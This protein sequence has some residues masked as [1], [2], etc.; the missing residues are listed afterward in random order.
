MNANLILLIIFIRR[1][2]NS[3]QWWSISEGTCCRSWF[4]ISAKLIYII[5]IIIKQLVVRIAIILIYQT[6]CI[7]LWWYT[8]LVR[9][10]W[11]FLMIINFAAINHVELRLAVVILILIHQIIILIIC[12]NA[13]T[14][15]NLEIKIMFL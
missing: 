14:M 5:I 2:S 13:F 9:N 7:A 11:I 12:L 3:I 15:C 6:A 8:I 1:C 4:V 10:W